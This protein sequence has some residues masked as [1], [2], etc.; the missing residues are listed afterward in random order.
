MAGKRVVVTG[1]G[2]VSSIGVG[3]E[4]FWKNIKEGKGYFRQVDFP[5]IEI[6]Q[7]KSRVCSPID[8]FTPVD[9]LEEGKKLKRTARAAQFTIVGT[10]LALKDAG[11]TLQPAVQDGSNGMYA[12]RG[13]D[14]QRCGVIIGQST[15]NADIMLSSH[16]RFFKAQRPEED[17]PSHFS[18]IKP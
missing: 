16:I 11:F 9:Y 8:N 10:Y 14:R 5:D 1:L 6:G 17:E 18:T 3:T 2:A 13:I 7:Y 4:P 15:N 12:V